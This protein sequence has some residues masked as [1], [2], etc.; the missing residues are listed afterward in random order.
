VL[1]PGPLHV[2][3]GGVAAAGEV[4]AGEQAP[5]LQP[6]V[7]PGQGLPVVAGGRGGLTSGTHDA[8]QKAIWPESRFDSA[9]K[10][11]IVVANPRHERE[12]YHDHGTEFL[13]PRS[14]LRVDHLRALSRPVDSQ[15][16]PFALS[17][18]PGRPDPLDVAT[19]GSLT[20]R[21][22]LR[23]LSAKLPIYLSRGMTGA[24]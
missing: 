17:V 16:G 6:G 20:A 13:H 4:L 1:A 19:P 22:E 2:H 23:G 18:S 21:K 14:N 8:A 12:I 24:G 9:A 15:S 3:K 7:D 11:M 10:F 5:A